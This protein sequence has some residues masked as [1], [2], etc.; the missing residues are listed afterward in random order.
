MK[1]GG[2]PRVSTS[3][4]VEAPRPALMRTLKR[5]CKPA[6]SQSVRP[7]LA[8]AAYGEAIPIFSSSQYD[9]ADKMVG[10]NLLGVIEPDYREFLRRWVGQLS[11]NTGKTSLHTV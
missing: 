7:Q 1:E 5:T 9:A 10:A 8:K 3:S 2:P 11:T 6:F 4:G